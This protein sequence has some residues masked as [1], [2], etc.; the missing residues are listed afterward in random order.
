MYANGATIFTSH[1]VYVQIYISITIDNINPYGY[2]ITGILL[3]MVMRTLYFGDLFKNAV[4]GI[5]SW[6][7]SFMYGENLCL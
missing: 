5:L 4:A 1:H 3:S 2:N 6:Q 7:I